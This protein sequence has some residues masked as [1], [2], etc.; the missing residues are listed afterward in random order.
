MDYQLL[1][2]DILH[3]IYKQA[4]KLRHEEKMKKG[5]SASTKK[6]VYARTIVDINS[7]NVGIPASDVLTGVQDILDTVFADAT[8][9][10]KETSESG[11]DDGKSYDMRVYVLDGKRYETEMSDSMLR[12]TQVG[13]HS[14]FLF[15]ACSEGRHEWVWRT[16]QGVSDRRVC[17]PRLQIAWCITN[18]RGS[19]R[20]TWVF[21]HAE[22]EEA[23]GVE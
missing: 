23:L 20:A 8:V 3:L 1:P 15:Q 6:K 19:T 14:V 18:G 10:S 22:S 2:T 12:V 5:P 13:D 17:L 9:V 16:R 21:S 4:V 11:N 7:G